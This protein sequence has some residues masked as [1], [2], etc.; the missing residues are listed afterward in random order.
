MKINE[1]D[2]KIV[3]Q[4]MTMKARKLKTFIDNFIVKY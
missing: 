2:K 4:R 3:K 1:S